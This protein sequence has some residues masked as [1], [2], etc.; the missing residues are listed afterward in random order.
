MS[1]EQTI[2][3]VAEP[4]RSGDSCKF[5]LEPALFAGVYASFPDAESGRGSPFIVALFALEGVS[6]V[7]LAPD[8]LTVFTSSPD[9]DWRVL[10]K[11]VGQALRAQHASGTPPLSA[12]LLASLASQSEL[13][14]RVQ[15]ILDNDINPVVAGHGGHIKLL[16]VKGHHAYVELGGGCQGCGMASVTLKQGVE[17]RIRELVPE[18]VAVIDQTDHAGGNNPYF[19]PSK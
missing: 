19:R 2:R 6:R 17:A 5:T 9:S 4:S 14:D 16:E 8:A 11:Q 7:L 3:I 15:E 18:I 12:E 13:F 10:G 1:S